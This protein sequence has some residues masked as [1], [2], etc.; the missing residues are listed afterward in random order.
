MN[1]RPGRDRRLLAF[2]GRRL[3]TSAVL[4]VLLSGFVFVGVELLPGDPVTARLGP[5]AP[6]ADV[7]VARQRLGLDRPLPERYADW[8]GGLLRGD[9]GTSLT[10]GRPVRALLAERLGNSVLLAVVTVALVVPLSLA[11]GVWAGV[12][13]GGRADRALQLGTVALVAV[14][15]YVV[16][17]LLVVVVSVTL[18]LLPA[19]S[20]VPAGDSP[21]SHPDVLVLPVLSLLLLSLAYAV[22]VIRASTAAGLRAPHVAA[23]R[24]NGT[25]DGPVLRRAVLPA[26]LP[27]AVQIWALLAVGLV[28]GAVLI[29]RVYG[30]PGIG[31]TLVSAVQTGDLPVA[32][33]L[34]MLLGGAMLVALLLADLTVVLLTPRLR[35]TV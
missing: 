23:A 13:R 29:E 21:L 19:V 11:I 8:A 26:V 14:P 9:L 28:G 6:A 17:G 24:L 1:R 15:E 27:V 12:H 25:A 35:T 10:S 5:T 4:L 31:E 34:A 18:G 20:L 7:A 30:Y 32:Q 3:G 33:A 16:A 22:R 2:A